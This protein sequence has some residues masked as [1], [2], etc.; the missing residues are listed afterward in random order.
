MPGNKQALANFQRLQSSYEILKDEKAR[1]LFDDLLQ[2]KRE[3][4]HRRSEQESRRDAK[5]QKMFSDLEEREWAAFAPDP[6]AKEREE[7]D[8]IAKKLREEI[9][10]IRAMYASKGENMTLATIREFPGVK[11]E[12]TSITKPWVD[13]EKLLKVSWEKI[14]EDYTAEGLRELF[15]KFG[16]VEDVVIKSAKKKG[17]ALVVMENKD[18]VVAAT[19]S[20]SGHLSNP[21]LVLPL[22]PPM[23]TEAPSASRSAKPDRL[24]NLFGAGYIAFEDAIL[25]KLQK[26]AEKRK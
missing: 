23:V 25:M 8:R 22:Q 4:Q 7:E 15:L 11:K 13:K 21:L 14:G 5:R 2:V 16:E 3:Q 20:V 1:K 17:S 26:A 12:S 18:A 10:R 19:G 6:F 24:S 9:A